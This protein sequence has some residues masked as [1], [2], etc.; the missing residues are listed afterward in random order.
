MET[1]RRSEWGVYRATCKGSASSPTGGAKQHRRP[2]D[3]A[4]EART[5]RMDTRYD[6]ERGRAAV[7]HDKVATYYCSSDRAR[8]SLGKLDTP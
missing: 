4:D 5:E 2:E 1:R 3:G 6:A 8:V 7:R